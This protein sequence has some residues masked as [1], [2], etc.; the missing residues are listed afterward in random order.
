M[1]DAKVEEI[2]SGLGLGAIGLDED[3]DDLSGGQRTKVLLAKLLLE[4]P[5]ILILDEPTNYLD[6]EHIVW[7]KVFLTNY[8]NAFILVSHDTTFLNEVTNVIYHIENA[9]LTRYKG[10]FEN[11]T[12]MYDLK[13]RQQ[14]QAYEK[15]QKENQQNWRLSLPRTRQGWQR[16][17]WQRAVNGSW[18]RWN[19]LKR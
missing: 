2:A 10:D 1:I 11:F 3:V 7:L 4:S 19:A 5:M 18:I 17:I 15:Q 9:V 14:E 8:E 6:L 16:P 12:R 13:R